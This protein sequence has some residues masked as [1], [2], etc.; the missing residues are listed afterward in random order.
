M[1]WVGDCFDNSVAESFFGTL[2]LELLDEHTWRSRQHLALAVFGVDRSLVQP[3]TPPQLLQAQPGRRRSRSRG[4]I[5]NQPALSAR[6]G[7][8]HAARVA[9]RHQM[10]TMITGKADGTHGVGRLLRLF[11]PRF[12]PPR[13]D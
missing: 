6:P 8:A 12:M 9:R 4:I 3:Q 10:I 1:G 11:D 13:P 7:K 5:S 2:Q